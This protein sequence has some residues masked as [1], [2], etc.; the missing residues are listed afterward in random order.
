VL[1]HG[2]DAPAGLTRSRAEVEAESVAYLVTT[3]RGMNP[4]DYT[5]PYV[6]G[7]AAGEVGLVLDTAERVLSTAGA[8]LAAAPAPAAEPEQQQ[9]VAFT[10]TAERS[11]GLGLAA[12]S[13]A[14]VRPVRRLN[15]VREP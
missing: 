13:P 2:P 1:L 15:R 3:A 4:A 6:T 7:W 5:V 10:R 11:R 12:T 8:I 14:A 9:V